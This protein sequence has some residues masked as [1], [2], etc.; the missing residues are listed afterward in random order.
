M[1][2]GIRIN[3]PDHTLIQQAI[4]N[5]IIKNSTRYINLRREFTRDSVRRF[6]LI[7]MDIDLEIYGSESVDSDT[8]SRIVET[9]K[10]HQDQSRLTQQ[11]QTQQNLI[12]ILEEYGHTNFSGNNPSEIIR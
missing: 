12:Q 11:Q 5:D 3:S 1:I 6:V 9:I 4:A 10:Y 8:W 2:K 7:H